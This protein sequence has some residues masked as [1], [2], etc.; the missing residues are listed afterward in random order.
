MTFK[1]EKN[2]TSCRAHLTYCWLV[3]PDEK[4]NNY[5]ATLL[6]KP[7]MKH[8]LDDGTEVNSAE[9]M[10]DQ[11]EGI[12]KEFQDSLISAYPDRKGKFKWQRNKDGEPMQY[13]QVTADGLTIKLKKKA[14]GL[15]KNGE[16]YTSVPP[17]FFKQEGDIMKLCTPEEVKRFDKIAPESIG[18][19]N[20]RISGYDMDYIGL[21]LEPQGICVR[22]FVPFVGGMQTAE[23][24]GFAPEKETTTQ[25]SWEAETI[26]SAGA[27]SGSDF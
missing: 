11:L 19:V 10:L 25:N 27:A 13:W 3:N 6:I 16:A 9:Y 18:Q 5:Q 7:N 15:K 24:F 21:K 23:D 14:G 26:G 12:K 2:L 1:F 8:L 20:I 17:K 4:Y 22:H